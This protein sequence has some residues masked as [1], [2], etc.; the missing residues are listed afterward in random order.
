MSQEKPAGG[1]PIPSKAVQIEVHIAE[2]KQL[3]NAI[4]PSPFRERDLDPNADEFIIGWARE[5]PRDAPLALLVRLDRG[6]GPP[7]ESA[8]QACACLR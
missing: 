2:L 5:A 4:D 7:G 3:F 1:D 6:A 8:A